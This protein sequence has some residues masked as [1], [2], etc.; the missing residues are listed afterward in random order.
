VT[1]PQGAFPFAA[2]KS[3]EQRL[4]SFDE[5]VYKAD[6]T[7][8][9]YKYL[10]AMCGST[11]AGALINQ[12]LLA[13]MC[14]SL[15]TIY[16]NDLD[17]IFG[18]IGFIPRSPAESYT[19]NPMTDQL[20]A[21]QWNEVRVKD[22]W[23]RARV[24][25]YFVACGLGGTP[26]GLRMAVKA[27]V[28]CDC[29]IYE[30]WRY[31]DNY[32]LTAQLG[33]SPSPARTEVVIKPHKAQL[34]QDEVRLLRDML[35]R[36]APVESIMTVNPQGLA[37]ISPVTVSAA[38]SDSEYFEVQRTVTATPALAQLP[39]PDLLPIDLLPT[40]TWLYQAQS[41][42]TLAPY[43]AFNITAQYGYYYLAGGGRRSPIDSVTY[44]TLND[45]G[46]VTTAPN[47][48][49]FD[50]TG[51]YGP[52]TPYAKADSPDNYPGGKYGIHPSTA[53]ALNPDGTPYVFPYASQQS[54]VTNQVNLIEGQG[55]LATAETYQLPISTPSSTARVFYPDYAIAYS[56]PAKDSTVSTSV[57]RDRDSSATVPELRDPIN[58]VRSH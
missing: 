40:E 34:A 28:N 15:S 11:G 39:A 36:L 12:A 19:F 42:P 22:A 37:V 16:F 58:F 57:T 47:F 8:I 33:R 53:P 17:F 30:E 9:L 45:D 4:A 10:D 27:A 29:D 3:T 13:R 49:T 41:N 18:K 25:D 5:Y 21:A 46:T 24:R 1:T 2:P 52:P 23:Y 7:T 14:G 38:A 43:T 32:G 48:Q 56:P 35:Q 31:I 51:Q 6:P 26:D 55:G 54:Y 50:T 20:T 44:G